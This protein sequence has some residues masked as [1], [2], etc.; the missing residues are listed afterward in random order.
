MGIPQNFQIYSLF[1][2]ETPIY[3]WMMNRDT[4]WYSRNLRGASGGPGAAKGGEVAKS[5]PG[6]GSDPGSVS[7]NPDV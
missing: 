3:K 5:A 6:L 4:P 7:G 2:M 1:N